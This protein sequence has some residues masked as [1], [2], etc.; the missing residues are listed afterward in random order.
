MSLVGQLV[1]M[2]DREIEEDGVFQFV[3]V[4]NASIKRAKEPRRNIG[5]GQFDLP[6]IG[7]DQRE[8]NRPPK[9]PEVLR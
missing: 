3:L 4:A 5:G 7:F 6:L 1:E 8:L 2:H 9:E